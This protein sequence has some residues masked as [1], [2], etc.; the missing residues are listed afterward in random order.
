LSGS[1]AYFILEKPADGGLPKYQP[2]VSLNQIEQFD[3]TFIC[4]SFSKEISVGKLTDKLKHA[5]L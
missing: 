3:L 4:G 1:S 5:E 2:Q